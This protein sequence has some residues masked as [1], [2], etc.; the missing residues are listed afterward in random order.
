MKRIAIIGAGM[1]GLTLAC[2]LRGRADVVVFEKGRGVGGRMATRRLGDY[3]FDHGAQFFTAR[4]PA[5]QRFLQAYQTQGIVQEWRPRVLTLAQGEKAYKRDWFEP[6]YVA[7]PGM[8]ALCKAMA[9]GIELRLGVP[10][11]RPQRQPDGR[12]RLPLGATKMN[13]SDLNAAALSDEFDWI[14]CTAPAP[15]ASSL[16]PPDFAYQALLASVVMSPCITLLLGLQETPCWRFDAAR[17]KH[18]VLD[19]ISCEASR[20][21]RGQQDGLTLHS[22]SSWAAAHLHAPD[23][24]LAA[25]MLDALQTVTGDSLPPI[26][27]QQI[28]RWHYAQAE[29]PEEPLLLLDPRL[30]LAACGDWANQ[31]RVEGAFLAAHNL[32][33][34]LLPAL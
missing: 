12:W 7:V 25:C 26:A 16:L 17:L 22:A 27:M 5:F 2:L 14:L 3:S 10:V 24:Y 19:W 33:K 23:E 30:Q 15:Q 31:P 11:G 29:T 4:T 18:P 9:A 28:K 34:A 32:A 20:P 1:A 13:S 21:G 8:T 6:H